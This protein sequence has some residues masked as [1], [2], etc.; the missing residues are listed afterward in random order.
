M[1]QEK[2]GINR[3]DES[4]NVSTSL[5]RSVLGS[6]LRTIVAFKRVIVTPSSLLLWCILFSR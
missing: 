1:K 4:T 5:G 2:S 6:R 3:G